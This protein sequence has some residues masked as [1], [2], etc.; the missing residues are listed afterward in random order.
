MVSS[1]GV[2]N[3]EVVQW[4]MPQVKLKDHIQSIGVAQSAPD[5][6]G[7]AKVNF[8]RLNKNLEWLSKNTHCIDCKQGG[9]PPDCAIRYCAKGRGYPVCNN[10]LNLEFSDKF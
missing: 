6:L 7:G 8:E 9:G 3:Y 4:L 1:A 10:C 5:L 2:V